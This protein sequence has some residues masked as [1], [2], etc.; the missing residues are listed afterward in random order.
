MLYLKKRYSISFQKQERKEHLASFVILIYLTN[1]L[2]NQIQ[3][4]IKINLFIPY[5]FL[6][7]TTR[8]KEARA[9]LAG[10]SANGA[11]ASNAILICAIANRRVSKIPSDA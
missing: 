4:K 11:I 5:L 6:V 1:H 10:L 3:R 7:K 2:T 8:H 9:V